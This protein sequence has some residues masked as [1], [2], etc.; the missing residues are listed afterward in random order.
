LSSCLFFFFFFCLLAAPQAS[1]PAQRQTLLFSAT[2]PKTLDGPI[3]GALRPPLFKYEV[4]GQ[5]KISASQNFQIFLLDS[6]I[7]II[8][9]LQPFFM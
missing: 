7:F 6:F 1:L 2:M 5:K 4:G 3:A 9:I 8:S